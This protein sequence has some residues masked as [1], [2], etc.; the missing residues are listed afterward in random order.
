M[1][2]EINNTNLPKSM[3]YGLTSATAVAASK[4]MARFDSVN[5]TSYSPSSANEVRIRIKANGFADVKHHYV[6]FTITGA[7]NNASV[8]THAG[9]FIDRMTIESGGSIV[10]QIN[11]Y[12]LYN[13]IRCNY[14]RSMDE[15]VKDDAGAGGSKLSALQA[16]GA[17]G[18]V[19]GADVAA[20]LASVNTQKDAFIAATNNLTLGTGM[21]SLAMPL[22]VADAKIFCIQLE[23]GLLKNH[24]EKALPDGLNE[25][26]LVLRLAG[27]K[28]AVVASNGS[29]PTWTMSEVSFN[30][31]VYQIQ[32]AG[33]MAEY[34]AAVADEG[35][36]ISGDTAKT[37]INSVVAGTGIKTLQINDRSLSCKALVTAIRDTAQDTTCEFYSNGAYGYSFAANTTQLESFKYIIGGVN[38]PQQDIKISLA[39]TTL[40]LGRAHDE[41]CKALAKHGDKYCNGMVTKQMLTGD[42]N[43]AYAAPP[44]TNSLLVPR[45]LVSIDLKKFSDD[46]LRMVGLNTSQNSS[47]NVLELNITTTFGVTADCTTFS[48]CEAFYSMDALGGLSVVQ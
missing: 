27:N 20:L 43:A 30:C 11:S 25:I 15:I 21:G 32:D 24:H 34:R 18:N 28:Q 1:Q 9:S 33:I 17:F 19:A 47:P 8:D 22:D 10:E 4:Q 48:I 45:G 41:T 6:Q 44:A 13:S 38:Y 5:G 42:I 14:N 3:R 35:V 37:Y 16:V 40:N 39:T 23:S 26:E 12:G 31:P 29:N 2:S 46:G 36:L 7:G